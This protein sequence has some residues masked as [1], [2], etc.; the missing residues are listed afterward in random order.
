MENKNSKISKITSYFGFGVIMLAC[1]ILIGV[2]ISSP[3][4]SCFAIDSKDR[5]YVGKHNRIDIYDSGVLIDTIRTKTAREYLFT[6]EPDDRLVLAT[7]T[8]VYHMDTSGNILS[9]VD[10]PT[11]DVHRQIKRARKEFVSQQSDVFHMRNV[12][13]WHYIVKNN[14]ELVYHISVLSFLTKIVLWATAAL[15]VVSVLKNS[16]SHK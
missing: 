1:V 8:T 3:F 9:T 13:G 10:D 14:S 6:I 16:K 12:F 15:F 5:V 4:V 2:E 11:G 7:S